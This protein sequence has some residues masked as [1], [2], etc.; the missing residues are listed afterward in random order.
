M[1]LKRLVELLKI[2]VWQASSVQY[3]VCRL[4]DAVKSII[5]MFKKLLKFVWNGAGDLPLDYISPYSEMPGEPKLDPK[6]ERA[7][8]APIDMDRLRKKGM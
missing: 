1:I 2:T 4:E 6:V 7:N 5:S 3:I 8:K